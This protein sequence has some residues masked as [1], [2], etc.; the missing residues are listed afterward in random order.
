MQEWIKKYNK[1][2]KQTKFFIW[3]TVVYSLSIFITTAY[4]YG[5]LDFVRSYPSPSTLKSHESKAPSKQHP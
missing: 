5:R 4:V 3:T 1:T 2:T